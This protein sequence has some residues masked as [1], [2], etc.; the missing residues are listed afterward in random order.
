MNFRYGIKIATD[1][2]IRLINYRNLNVEISKWK[3]NT[4]WKVSKNGV[5]SSLH[6]YLFSPNTGNTDQKKVRIWTFSTQCKLLIKVKTGSIIYTKS[7]QVPSNTIVIRNEN[8]FPFLVTMV[9]Y[10]CLHLFLV[11]MVT[12]TCLQ[13]VVIFVS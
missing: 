12:Y 9:K 8:I 13:S 6:F 7:L 11:T 2:R 4:A 1:G 5:F 3:P 10:T